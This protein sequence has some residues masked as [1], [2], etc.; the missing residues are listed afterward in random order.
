MYSTKKNISSLTQKALHQSGLYYYLL[1]C[2]ERLQKFERYSLSKNSGE[3]G[4]ILLDLNE[5]LSQ[6][7]K[8]ELLLADYTKVTGLHLRFDACFIKKNTAAARVFTPV[9]FT[10]ELSNQDSIHVYFSPEG[11]IIHLAP[12][13]LNPRQQQEVQSLA[14][15]AQAVLQKIILEKNNAYIKL[16]TESIQHKDASETYQDQPISQLL[17]SVRSYKTCLQ[18]LHRYSDRRTH[19]TQSA[20]EELVD[21]V[22]SYFEALESAPN[23]AKKVMPS[24][25]D[26]TTKKAAATISRQIPSAQPATKKSGAKLPLTNPIV[27]LEKKINDLLA[28]IE[29]CPEERKADYLPQ[30]RDAAIE[31]EFMD[32]SLKTSSTTKLLSA[33]EEQ[34]TALSPAIITTSLA[35][36]NAQA[37][38]QK[39]KAIIT[40]LKNALLTSTAR[41]KMSMECVDVVTAIPGSEVLFHSETFLIDMCND[42]KNIEHHLRL[43]GTSTFDDL[44]TQDLRKL[45]REK[46]TLMH[47]ASIKLRI[48]KTAL[49]GILKKGLLKGNPDQV[50]KLHP[51]LSEAFNLDD[52]YLNFIVN[53]IGHEERTAYDQ[54][55]LIAKYLHENSDV[56]RAIF[57][58]LSHK[59]IQT[60]HEHILIGLLVSAIQKNNVALFELFLQHGTCP[61]MVQYQDTSLGEEINI[62][63]LQYITYNCPQH[64]AEFAG[65][66]FKYGAAL[67]P[68]H[69]IAYLP[70][71]AWGATPYED[72]SYSFRDIHYSQEL[73]PITPE[74]SALNELAKY[75]LLPKTHPLLLA[76]IN[77]CLDSNCSTEALLLML[78]HI[79]RQP[80]FTIELSQTTSTHGL[81][82]PDARRVPEKNKPLHEI[83]TS[84]AG[85]SI[86]FYFKNLPTPE[87]PSFTNNETKQKFLVCAAQLVKKIEGIYA[88]LTPEEKK[89]IARNFAEQ[90]EKTIDALPLQPD[91][92][93][94]LYITNMRLIV[95][96]CLPL[97]TTQEESAA[98]LKSAFRLARF[99]KKNTGLFFSCAETRPQTTTKNETLPAELVDPSILSRR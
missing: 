73:I 58:T 25:H 24:G 93:K 61:D 30:L 46:N 98:W 43:L 10:I 48:V 7:G 52:V 64:A 37:T 22:I 12:T 20:Q 87:D 55:I 16:K 79:A 80:F 82:E 36:I 11:Q 96:A 91:V 97:V 31:L 18:T 29:T 88:Y 27:L 51:Y 54:R 23:T 72:G 70:S 57:S 9:H 56:Y 59:L 32:D 69:I 2:Y 49:L 19:D 15:M 47:E 45:T 85:V 41:I 40:A 21:T 8:L 84:L 62:C 65:L 13:T 81:D 83:Q 14:E 68:T 77:H 74:K 92:L 78:G 75:S 39:I 5:F 35:P 95:E 63:T 86:Y 71:I 26:S 94:N 76:M 60:D 42:A 28:I 38:K 3:T 34:I 4:C 17:V 90:A 89:T 44:D 53:L 66:L 33:C 6:K 67:D 1:D 50:M 99:N